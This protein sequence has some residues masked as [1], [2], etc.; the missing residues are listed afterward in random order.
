MGYEGIYEV[1][2]RGDVRSLSRVENTMG[3]YGP[4]RRKRSGKIIIQ[5]KRPNGYLS[6]EL[7]RNG[8][9]LRV[10]THIIVFEAFRGQRIKSKCIHHK[11][12]NKLNNHIQNLE[13]VSY[14]DHNKHH[15]H[16]PWNKGIKLGPAIANKAWET[17]RR[18]YHGKENI[19]RSI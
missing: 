13:E 18:S 12:G 19:N 1:S 3:R 8:E 16:I 6:V 15:S 14:K 10:A 5:N 4:M 11:D 17:K 2:E 7:N 9:S